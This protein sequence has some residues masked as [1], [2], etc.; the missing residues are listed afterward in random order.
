MEF[1]VAFGVRGALIPGVSETSGSAAPAGTTDS[2]GADRRP[3]ADIAARV[4]TVEQAGRLLGL[5]RASAYRAVHRW[6]ETG[7]AEGL[8]VVVIS[9]RRLVVPV[10]ALQRLLETALSVPS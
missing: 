6:L 2:A 1:L 5:S 9:H 7:G 3:L 4:L 10:A 8:P